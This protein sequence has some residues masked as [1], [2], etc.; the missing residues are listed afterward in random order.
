MTQQNAR[1]LLDDGS[2]LGERES[3]PFDLS[4]ALFS[5]QRPIL[6]SR[7]DDL[8]IMFASVDQ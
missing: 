2:L 7:L 6:L 4:L 1:D 8:R 3:S 5:L